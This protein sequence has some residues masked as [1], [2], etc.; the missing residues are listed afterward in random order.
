MPEAKVIVFYESIRSE[1][2]KHLIDLSFS[3]RGKSPQENG[4]GWIRLLNHPVWT[5]LVLSIIILG[6]VLQIKTY[7]FYLH[8]F[9]C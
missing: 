2:T 9:Q 7:D 1:R 3:Y 5:I 4:E 6:F 8:K